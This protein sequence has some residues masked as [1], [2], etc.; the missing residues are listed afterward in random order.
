MLDWKPEADFDAKTAIAKQAIQDLQV[1]YSM[2]IDSGQYDNLDNVFTPDVV[3]DYG[4]TGLTEGVEDLKAT[5]RLALDPLTSSQHLNG[6]HW[7]EID[8]DRA[9][10]GCYFTVHQ[11][12][13]GTP[14]GEHYEM[15]GVYEDDLVRTDAGWRIERR[16]LRLVWSDGNPAVRWDR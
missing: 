6:N 15:G 3:A 10:A 9:R 8:G 12:R 13:E 14:D 2:S 4:P 11:Y 5:C 16:S 7:A 1:Y